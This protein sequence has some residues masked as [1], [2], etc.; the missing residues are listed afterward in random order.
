MPGPV[1]DVNAGFS[2]GCEMKKDI[3]IFYSCEIIMALRRCTM[4]QGV[5]FPGFFF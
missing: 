3:D 2:R 1:H 5:A 4:G